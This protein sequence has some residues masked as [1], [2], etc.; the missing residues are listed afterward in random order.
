MSDPTRALAPAP[1][2]AAASLAALQGLMLLGLGLVELASWDSDRVVMNVTTTLSFVGF[3]LAMLWCTLNLV[4]G[5][6]WARSPIVFAQLIQLG[7]AYSF[8][9]ALVIALVLLATALVALAG[10]LHPDSLDYLAD[11]DPTAA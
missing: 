1:L 5:R 6:S 11:E 7:L 9:D 2:K 3:G 10:V 4:R 8:R